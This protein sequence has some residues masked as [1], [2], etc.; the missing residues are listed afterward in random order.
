MSNSPNQPPQTK[1]NP[2]PPDS[3]AELVVQK[4]RESK[5]KK[6]KAWPC[7]V[8]RASSLGHD[9]ER[10]LVYCRTDWNRRTLHPWEV[11]AIFD[12]GNR[13]EKSVEDDLREAGFDIVEQQRPFAFPE[14][15]ITGHIDGKLFIPPRIIPYE[16]KSM[17]PYIWD[18][19]KTLDDMIHS[20]YS[21][22]RYYPSQLNLY[23]LMDNNEYGIFILKNKSNGLIKVIDMHLD[24]EL[25]ETLL[26]KAERINKHV[27][28]GTK[29]DQ[30]MD[31][32]ICSRCAFRHLCLPDM[33]AGLEFTEGAI[34]DML[35]EWSALTV[36]IK[37]SGI[38]EDQKRAKQLN[39]H[40]KIIFKDR[41][42]VMAGE[43]LVTGKWQK[44][45]TGT[46]WKVDVAHPTK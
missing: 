14:L 35:D 37:S 26:R 18:T 1:E 3:I 23:L 41:P 43:Y 21:W 27:K 44:H 39:E 19:I 36:K 12:E 28:N 25:G 20:K 24:Y 10:Y 38:P 13:Q 40:F 29:P 4:Y 6:I 7:H 42:R 33:G 9:C 22:V 8:N 34:I 30:I 5:E 31:A 32:D 46:Y 15:D 11:Q 16:T 2:C 17:S 45:G